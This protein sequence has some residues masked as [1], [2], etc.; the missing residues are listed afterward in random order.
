MLIYLT[1]GDKMIVYRKTTS[2]EVTNLCK[3]GKLDETSGNV[4]FYEYSFLADIMPTGQY[5][6]NTSNNNLFMICDIPEEILQKY[7]SYAFC[8]AR[9]LSINYLSCIPVPEYNLPK[10][11]FNTNYILGINPTI[12]IEYNNSLEFQKYLVLFEKA[13]KLFNSLDDVVNF[14]NSYDRNEFIDFSEIEIKRNKK[15]VS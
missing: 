13:Y 3:N 12:P 14:F 11:L 9:D 8:N 7:Q 4:K 6:I 10:N 5:G 1:W 15:G 2:E